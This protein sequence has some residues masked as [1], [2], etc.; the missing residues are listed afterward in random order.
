MVLQYANGG[1]FNSYINKIHLWADK[2]RLLKSVICG[3]ENI[4]KNQMVHRDFHTGNILIKKKGLH[5]YISDL[6]LSGEV[7]NTD[8]TKFMELYLM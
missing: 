6:G 4:H 5:S 3:L 8:K 1:N 2:L 7:G